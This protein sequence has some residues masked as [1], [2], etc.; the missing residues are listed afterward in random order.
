MNPSQ[1]K[2][3]LGK[4]KGIGRQIKGIHFALKQG[5]LKTLNSFTKFH[6]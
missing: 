6:H 3:V 5:V 2:Y 1:Y 4:K